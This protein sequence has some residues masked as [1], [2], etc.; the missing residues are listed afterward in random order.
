MK[1]LLAMMFLVGLHACCNLVFH[2]IS[3]F[4]DANLPNHG[5]KVGALRLLILL[6]GQAKFIEWATADYATRRDK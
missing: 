1:K 5:A 4:A 3:R 2:K 6:D